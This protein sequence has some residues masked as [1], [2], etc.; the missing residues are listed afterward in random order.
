MDSM[1]RLLDQLM[2]KI[3]FESK[4]NCFFKAFMRIVCEYKS[5]TDI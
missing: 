3:V 5:F 1:D 2:F 4:G